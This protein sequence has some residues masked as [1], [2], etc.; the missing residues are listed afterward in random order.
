MSKIENNVEIQATEEAIVEVKPEGFF[1][2]AGRWIAE[3]K[4]AVAVTAAAGTALAF[5][6][7]AVVKNA[8]ANQDDTDEDLVDAEEFDYLADDSDEE[9]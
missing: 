6:V 5:I 3:H 1:T 8:K 4:V 7:G 2:K 9:S